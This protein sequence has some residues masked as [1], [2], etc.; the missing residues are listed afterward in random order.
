MKKIIICIVSVCLLMLNFNI[1][2]CSCE[3]EWEVEY[4][5]KESSCCEK[6]LAKYVCI[7]C[8]ETKE[9]ELELKAHDYTILQSNTATCTSKGIAQFKCS[10]CDEIEERESLAK[11]HSYGS[12]DVCKYCDDV[13]SG[14]DRFY[15]NGNVFDYASTYVWNNV[16]IGVA[17]ESTYGSK[18]VELKLL[19]RASYNR[20]ILWSIT[21]INATTKNIEVV[22]IGTNVAGSMNI[23]TKNGVLHSAYDST[24]KYY[25]KVSIS[26]F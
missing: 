5:V 18:S 11:G 17:I 23:I 12:A 9:E 15:F 22:F 16:S 24:N 4:I 20:S 25:I 14:Y 21:L 8:K 26:N 6:G 3:H 19:L 1:S 7:N 2:G 13:K 10:T